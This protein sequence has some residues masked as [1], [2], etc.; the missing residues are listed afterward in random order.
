MKKIYFIKYII[1]ALSSALVEFII[2]SLVCFF[3]RKYMTLG[4]AVLLSTVIGRIVSSLY[5]Y[6]VNK[7]GVFSS[8]EPIRTTLAKYYL[9]VICQILCSSKLITI[10][11]KLL[12][13]GDNQGIIS[14]T[15]LLVD[16]LLFFATYYI[17]KKWIFKTKA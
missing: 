4:S 14:G 13:V 17:Q 9:L 8:D 12:G 5:N 10:I 2:F 6:F 1:S 16:S 7:K 15:K 11:V 3:A